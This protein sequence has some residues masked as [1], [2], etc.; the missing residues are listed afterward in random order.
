[1]PSKYLGSPQTCPVMSKSLVLKFRSG[2]LKLLIVPF[3]IHI[4]LNC[5]PEGPNLHNQRTFLR[6]LQVGSGLCVHAN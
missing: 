4:S 5:S 2:E 3:E 6:H 1:M